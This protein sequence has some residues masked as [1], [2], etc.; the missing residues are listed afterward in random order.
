MVKKAKFNPREFN[1]VLKDS[2][3]LPESQQW[4]DKQNDRLQIEAASLGLSR[5]PFKFTNKIMGKLSKAQLSKVHRLTRL[6]WVLVGVT[7]PLP[8]K[9]SEDAPF[10][11]W[12]QAVD[13]S[14][15][16]IVYADEAA[17]VDIQHVR[18]INQVQVRNTAK[19]AATA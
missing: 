15:W 14:A 13:G 7:R 17:T 3:V 8:I 12:L 4:I 6:G 11:V 5:L 19:W 2:L 16:C 10:V 18:R 9:S 1:R